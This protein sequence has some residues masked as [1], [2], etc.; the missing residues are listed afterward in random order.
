MT[1]NRKQ[2]QLRPLVSPSRSNLS[3]IFPHTGKSTSN[4]I[5]V[6]PDPVK[7]AVAA[8]KPFMSPQSAFNSFWSEGGIAERATVTTDKETNELTLSQNDANNN[9]MTESNKTTVQ[10]PTK[11]NLDSY[12]AKDK[13][14]MKNSPNR[15]IP[16]PPSEA[17]DIAIVGHLLS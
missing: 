9:K 8:T 10:S 5:P 12:I 2:S 13:A 17:T 1:P 7:R 6:S 14:A 16:A 11:S 4:S 3:G 15:S